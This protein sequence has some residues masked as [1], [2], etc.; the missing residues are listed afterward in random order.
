MLK[1]IRKFAHA[2]IV[3][4]LAA[5]TRD[6]RYYILF[7][8]AQCNLREYMG[9]NKFAE[10]NAF[11]LL[12]QFHGMA[13]AMKWIHDLE[14]KTSSLTLN[15]SAPGERKTAWHH[16]IKPDNILYFKD[17]SQGCGT[18]RIS[19]WGCGKVSTYRTGSYNIKSP[20]GTKLTSHQSILIRERRRGL[21]T[22]GLWAASS[23]KSLF[24]RCLVRKL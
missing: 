13:E 18:F 14:P 17:T 3:T 2:H 8:L 12:D 24:G 1:E 19:D 15:T 4:R 6:E 10:N 11:W 20:I 7:P 5:W 22:Y 21:M 16:D 23:L 9:Q